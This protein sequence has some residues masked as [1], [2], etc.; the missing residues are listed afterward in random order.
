MWL[1]VGNSTSQCYI[2]F[3]ETCQR[4]THC[5][6]HVIPDIADAGKLSQM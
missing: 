3:T 6:N 2:L 5:F 1:I 4:V